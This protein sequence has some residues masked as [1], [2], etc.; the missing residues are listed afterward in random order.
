MKKAIFFLVA[1]SLFAGFSALAADTAQTLNV[2]S[3]TV[4][5]SSPFYF[6]KEIGRNIQTALTIDPVK[7]AELK[8]KF[9]NEK[10]AEAEKVSETENASN[11]ANALE[12]YENELKQVQQYVEVLKKDNPNSEKLLEKIAENT[13]NHQQ[14]LDEIADNKNE[15][16]EKVTE[17]KQKAV[18]TLT[19]GSFELASSDKVKEAIQNAADQN[20]AQASDKVEI[21]KKIEAAAPEEA[22]KSVA[23]VQNKIIA[24]GLNI[25]GLTDGE[26]QKL[27]E[28]LSQLKETDEYKQI[29]LEDIVQEIV[30]ENGE[31]F[32]SINSISEEDKAK[33]KEYAESILSGKETDYTKI[34]SGINSLDISSDTKEIINKIKDEALNNKEIKNV[35]CTM[36]Y[37]PVCG[38]DGKTYSNECVINAAGVKIKSS[39]ECGSTSTGIANPASTFCVKNGYKLEI[40]K[41]ADGSEYG[42]CVFSDGKECEEWKFFRGE[43]GKEYI[44]ATT[45]D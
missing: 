37:S 9:A 13:L 38:E 27:E 10:L 30:S 42:V 45:N 4:L 28:Y 21:L 36:I 33:L 1:L 17:V 23:E 18:E 35:A 19:S 14:V 3:P 2:S 16:Q 39:G 11:T 8:L 34:I 12:N 26:K 20:S 5:P 24:D 40:R 43:C 7:K 25:T 29:A 31:I 32:N 6:L 15:V 41:N 22:K 44:K